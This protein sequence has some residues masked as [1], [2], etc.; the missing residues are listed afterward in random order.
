MGVSGGGD[1]EAIARA[2]AAQIRPLVA[3]LSS[4][5]AG[6]ELHIHLNVDGRELASVIAGQ[7]RQGHKDLIEQTRRRIQ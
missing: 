7:Y 2:L 6:G 3:A 4:S 5:G 1:P